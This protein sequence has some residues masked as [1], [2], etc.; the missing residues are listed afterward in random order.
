MQKQIIL[1]IDDNP[2]ILRTLERCLKARGFGVHTAA[3][4][5]AALDLA[6]KRRHDLVLL[7][8]QMPGLSLRQTILGLQAAQRGIIVL[9]MTGGAPDSLIAEGTS[10]GAREPVLKPFGMDELV[11][12]I[13]A[14]LDGGAASAE[15]R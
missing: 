10:L 14:L 11:A 13:R 9:L 8:I 3:E 12:R 4:R 7:D 6:A 5:P 1:V 2:R 15:A